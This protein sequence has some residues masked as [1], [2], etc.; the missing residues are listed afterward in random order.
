MLSNKKRGSFKISLDMIEKQPELVMK[1][2]GK[3]IVIDSQPLLYED[4]IQYIAVSEEF[5]EIQPGEYIPAYQVIV[6][7]DTKEVMFK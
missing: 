2:M 5:K 6:N 7:S 1:I 4:C 3:C